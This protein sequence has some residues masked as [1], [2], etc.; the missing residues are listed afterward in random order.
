M[1]NSYYIRAC[2]IIIITTY[3]VVIIIVGNM[4]LHSLHLNDFYWEFLS[5]SRIPF[6]EWSSLYV[7]HHCRKSIHKAIIMIILLL[8]LLIF[9]HTFLTKDSQSSA[10]WMVCKSYFHCVSIVHI[11]DLHDHEMHATKLCNMK[12]YINVFHAQRTY[13]YA[14]ISPQKQLS[15]VPL[16][17]REIEFM[18]RRWTYYCTYLRVSYIFPNIFPHSNVTALRASW[19]F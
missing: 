14:L 13:V 3:F 5:N 1:R 7:F 8:V 15:E 17:V 18:G 12:R 9:S 11:L 10:Q 16:K 4:L 19:I 6:S 2:Y